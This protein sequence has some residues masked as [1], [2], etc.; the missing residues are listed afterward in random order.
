M[1]ERKYQD[2]GIAGGRM[3]GRGEIPSVVP[4][5]QPVRIRVPEPLLE[6]VPAFGVDEGEVM[7]WD[8]SI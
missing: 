5:E 6:E 2:T 8:R 4:G 7:R 3:V 1:V